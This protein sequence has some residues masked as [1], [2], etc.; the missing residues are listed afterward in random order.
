MRLLLSGLLVLASCRVLPPLPSMNDPGADERMFER[1]AAVDWSKAQLGVSFDGATVEAALGQG[2]IPRQSWEVL[3]PGDYARRF[4]KESSGI[5]RLFCFYVMETSALRGLSVFV[6]EAVHG[7]NWIDIL[8]S[9]YNEFLSIA[10]ELRV[11]EAMA[12]TDPDKALVVISDGLSL[13]LPRDEG[14]RDQEHM[15][16]RLMLCALLTTMSPTE[17]YRWARD[18]SKDDFKSRIRQAFGQGPRDVKRE[19]A[20]ALSRR[21][22]GDDRYLDALLEMRDEANP[23]VRRERFLAVL[24]ELPVDSPFRDNLEYQILTCDL[25]LGRHAQ[26]LARAEELWERMRQGHLASQVALEAYEAACALHL[27]AERDT[28]HRRSSDLPLWRQQAWLGELSRADCRV[29]HGLMR[30]GEA[31]DLAGQIRASSFCRE[32]PLLAK[33]AEAFA[34]RALALELQPRR[35]QRLTDEGL[36]RALAEALRMGEE[37]LVALAQARLGDRAFERGDLPAAVAAYEATQG[38]GKVREAGF[39]RDLHP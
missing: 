8:D 20:A 31:L 38:A 22:F 32:L 36:Q 29:R 5:R 3:T 1:L 17:I 34:A 21:L 14:Y 35:A 39:W 12:P 24:G 28:W 7:Y 27:A 19:G 13:G 30:L 15:R 6:H 11:A 25:S 23:R 9:E 18:T 10:G 37:E 4:P 16:A 2:F 26:V 33:E